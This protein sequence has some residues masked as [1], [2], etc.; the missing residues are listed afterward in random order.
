[1]ATKLENFE[2]PNSC[3][4]RADDTEQVFVF[5]QRDRHAPAL[6]RLWAE[7]REK[8]GEDTAVVNDA[9]TVAQ[10]MEDASVAQGR[11]FL[12]LN[13]VLSLAASLKRNAADVDGSGIPAQETPTAGGQALPDNPYNLRVGDI[14]VAGRGRPAKLVR[15]F[16]TDKD[17]PEAVRGHA[18][19]QLPG[20]SPVTVQFD[21]LRRAAPEEVEAYQN[22]GGRM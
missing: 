2:D 18:N 16:G 6:I 10:L 19:I 9:R 3:W 11:T 13:A 7:M 21:M 1:M 4:S 5:R 22:S 14:V 8:E 20:T 12:S 17:T 15:V